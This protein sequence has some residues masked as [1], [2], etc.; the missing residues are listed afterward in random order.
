MND[1]AT[2][3][4]V[5]ILGQ[6]NDLSGAALDALTKGKSGAPGGQPPEGPEPSG[7]HSEGPPPGA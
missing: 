3:V 6:I 2:K 5:E 1:E 7:P 4:L